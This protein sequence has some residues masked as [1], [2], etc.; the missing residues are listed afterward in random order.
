VLINVISISELSLLFPIEYS[1]IHFRFYRL[2]N[3]QPVGVFIFDQVIVTIINSNCM[4]IA[5]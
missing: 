4:T 3:N 5:P 1:C 2:H